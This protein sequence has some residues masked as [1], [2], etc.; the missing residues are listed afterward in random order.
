VAAAS[1]AVSAASVSVLL[2]AVGPPGD[3]VLRLTPSLVPTVAMLESL[4]CVQATGDSDELVHAV[5]AGGYGR[6]ASVSQ[7]S[8]RAGAPPDPCQM[9]P[10]G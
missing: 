2:G 4:V 6:S 5:N 1:L 7:P 3:D 9:A 8:D 10:E